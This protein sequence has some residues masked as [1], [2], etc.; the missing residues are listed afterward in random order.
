MQQVGEAQGRFA[1]RAGEDHLLGAEEAAEETHRQE[2]AGEEWTG[3]E[4]RDRP[5]IGQAAERRTVTDA[6]RSGRGQA[7]PAE[8]VPPQQVEQGERRPT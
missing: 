3:P 8:A 1:G 2:A 5:G 4:E 7:G 6:K